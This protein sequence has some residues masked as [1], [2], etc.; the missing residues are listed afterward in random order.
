MNAAMYDTAGSS[1]EGLA[2]G[3]VIRQLM[4]MVG[5]KCPHGNIAPLKVIYVSFGVIATFVPFPQA[6][7]MFKPSNH[8]LGS[9]LTILSNSWTSRTTV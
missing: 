4:M 1:H 7:V 5:I 8:S 9:L 3:V 6:M 2:C